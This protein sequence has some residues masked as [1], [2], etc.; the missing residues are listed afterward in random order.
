MQKRNL[1]SVRRPAAIVVRSPHMGPVG[2]QNC[3]GDRDLG[4]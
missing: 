1:A 3:A 4:F 2:C